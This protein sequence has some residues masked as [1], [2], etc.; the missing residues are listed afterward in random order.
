MPTQQSLVLSEPWEASEAPASIALSEAARL[1][2]RDT[3]TLR[4]MLHVLGI[5]PESDPSDRR[6]RLLTPQ[7]FEKLKHYVFQ[8]QRRHVPEYSTTSL[9]APPTQEELVAQAREIVRKKEQEELIA[10]T[11]EI[12]REQTLEIVREKE[13]YYEQRE[14]HLTEREKKLDEGIA[15]LVSLV[16]ALVALYGPEVDQLKHLAEKVKA[17]A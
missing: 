5:T 8:I 7:D 6:V 10:H 17:R 9:F 12:V 2:H 1:L 13:Q 11:R 4:K 14:A 15:K 16:D 3:K